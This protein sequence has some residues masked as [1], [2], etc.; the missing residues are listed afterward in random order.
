MKMIEKIIKIGDIV[1]S[2]KTKLQ[3]TDI[4]VALYN[5]GTLVLIIKMNLIQV[6]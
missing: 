2:Y 1:I 4:Y 3:L 6:M 5:D